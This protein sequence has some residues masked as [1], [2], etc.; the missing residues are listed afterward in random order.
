MTKFIL[1]AALAAATLGGAG[2]ASAQYYPVPP[3]Y[4]YD[5]PPP[6]RRYYRERDYDGPRYRGGIV[7]DRYGQP[8]CADRRFTIQDGVCK[9]YRGY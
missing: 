9:P 8:H 6:P 3:G 7:Y 4:F 5:D 1:A 2:T